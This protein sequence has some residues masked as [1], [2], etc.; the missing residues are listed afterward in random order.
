MTARPAAAFAAAS[1]LAAAL[2]ACAGTRPPDMTVHGIV[3]LATRQFS[4]I[5][6]GGDGFNP[7]YY[8]V[9]QGNAQVT[10]TDPSGKVLA[11]ASLDNGNVNQPPLGAPGGLD[12][13]TGFT[14]KVPQGESFYGVSV[15]GVSGTIHFTQ[16]QMKA[17][18][19]LCAGDAC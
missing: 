3:E 12:I 19:S 9:D 2:S 17:G 7:S 10:V 11:V 6:P 8:Q 13:N 18:P 4:E 1:I 14:V 15:S 16:A 5:Q